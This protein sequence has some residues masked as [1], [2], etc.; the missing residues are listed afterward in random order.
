[1]HLC[2][3]KFSK[4]RE[5]FYL[6]STICAS[7]QSRGHLSPRMKVMYHMAVVM[8]QTCSVQVACWHIRFHS[9]K[10]LPPTPAFLPVIS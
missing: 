7:V 8:Q 10:P 2:H 9:N 4:A 3:R 6:T 1:M 5:L